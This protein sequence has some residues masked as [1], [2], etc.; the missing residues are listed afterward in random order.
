MRMTKAQLEKALR[1]A[2]KE[3]AYHANGGKGVCPRATL[4]HNFCTTPQKTCSD[5]WEK[6]L[7]EKARE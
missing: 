6:Y 2:C 4:V 5:C 1:L 7:T 3:L